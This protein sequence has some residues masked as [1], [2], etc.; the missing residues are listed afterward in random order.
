[1]TVLYPLKHFSVCVVSLVYFVLSLVV[2]ACVEV[3][4]EMAEFNEVIYYKIFGKFGAHVMIT[5]HGGNRQ[6]GISIR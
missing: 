5:E 1:M 2:L 6:I 3:E 4:M